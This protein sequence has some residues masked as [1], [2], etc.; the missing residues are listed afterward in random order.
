MNCAVSAAAN[1]AWSGSRLVRVRVGPGFPG[2]GGK[3]HHAPAQAPQKGRLRGRLPGCSVNLVDLWPHVGEWCQ[4]E[5][6]RFSA[7]LC[8]K[9]KKQG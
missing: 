4:N 6:V 1:G 8:A 9:A 2:F 7:Q 5:S 3:G